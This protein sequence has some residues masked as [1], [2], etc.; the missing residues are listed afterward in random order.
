MKI[1]DGFLLKEVAG[2]FV[3][4][5]VGDV[6][7]EAMLTLNE[8]GLLIWK[9]LEDGAEKDTLVKAILSEYDITEEL[10]EKDVEAFLQKLSNAGILEK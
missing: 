4:V 3:V 5:P 2:N 9:L 7:F 6:S 8:T 10:A 1:K